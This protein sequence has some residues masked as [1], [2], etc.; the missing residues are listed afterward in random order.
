MEGPCLVIQLAADTSRSVKAAIY[1]ADVRR[2]I[3]TPSA[4]SPL[5]AK[6]RGCCNFSGRHCGVQ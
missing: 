5:R 3:I 4:L 2:A 1:R 6:P